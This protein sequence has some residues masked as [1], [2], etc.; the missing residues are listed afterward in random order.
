M[1][2]LV[3]K[4][5]WTI[6]LQKIMNNLEHYEVYKYENYLKCMIPSFYLLNTGT[7]QIS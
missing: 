3:L 5:T 2:N 7:V 1:N 4:K 6:S